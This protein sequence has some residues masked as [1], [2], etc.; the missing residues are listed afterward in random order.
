M[1]LL[2]EAGEPVRENLKPVDYTAKIAEFWWK[3]DQVETTIAADWGLTR[4]T[5]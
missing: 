5:A 3:R 2:R 1:C 4:A